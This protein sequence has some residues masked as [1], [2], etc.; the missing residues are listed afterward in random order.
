MPGGNEKG[1]SM[2]CLDLNQSMVESTET[3]L[4]HFNFNSFFVWFFLS[5]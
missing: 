5:K 4:T 2:L 1:Q 3:Q